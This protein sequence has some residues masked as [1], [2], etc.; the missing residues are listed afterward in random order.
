MARRTGTRDAVEHAALRLVA[1]EPLD[2][3]TVTA[4]AREAGIT[5]ETLYRHYTGVADA[6]SSALERELQVIGEANSA[7][8]AISATGDSVF[9]APTEQLV[10][11]MERRSGVYRHAMNP[12]LHPQLRDLLTRYVHSGLMLHLEQHPEIAPSI[13]GAPPTPFGRVALVA[14][15]AAGTVGVFEHWLA[16]SEADS[17][18]LLTDEILAAAPEWWQGLTQPRQEHPPPR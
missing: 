14:Y 1:A 6:L 5:R 10:Q 2:D 8:P 7:L 16:N 17:P 3:V 11:H 9:R 15:A 13:A 12:G 18:A 4:L